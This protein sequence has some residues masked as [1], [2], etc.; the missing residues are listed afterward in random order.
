MKRTGVIISAL[1][2]MVALALPAIAAGPDW[3]S[4]GPAPHAHMLILASGDCVDL[5]ANQVAP[6][7]AQH[8]HLHRGAAG[9][10]QS[11]AGHSIIPTAPITAWADCAAFL[12]D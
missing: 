8:A 1:V 5:A 7:N 4:G 3:P 12:A 11:L 9:A 2:M 6:I 10:A